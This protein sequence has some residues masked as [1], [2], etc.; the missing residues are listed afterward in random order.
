V[1][2]LIFAGDQVE[3]PVSRQ[4]SKVRGVHRQGWGGI[5]GL[6]G[7]RCYVDLHGA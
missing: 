3:P 7:W 4:R 5:S 2:Q 1:P 6:T